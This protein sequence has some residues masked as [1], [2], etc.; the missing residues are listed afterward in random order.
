MSLQAA[1]INYRTRGDQG[2]AVVL[3]HPIGFDL[4]TWESVIPYLCDGYRLLALDIP[5]HGQSDKPR[6]ADYSVP[7]LAARILAFLDEIG[8]R[9]AAFVGNSLGGG[10]ALAAALQAPARV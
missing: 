8:W 1:Q 2:P 4:H 6:G 10:I 5:G 9:R 3:L 7:V